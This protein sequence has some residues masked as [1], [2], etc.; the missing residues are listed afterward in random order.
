MYG[1]YSVESVSLTLI[2]TLLAAL[3]VL[4]LG[5]AGTIQGTGFA[6]GAEPAQA[7]AELAA[8]GAG[9]HADHVA[10]PGPDITDLAAP[11]DAGGCA[12]LG[13]CVGCAMHCSLMAVVGDAAAETLQPTAGRFA[14][15][16]DIGGAGVAST[17]ERPPAAV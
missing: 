10:P 11:D 16:A 7:H 1:T 14:K 8:D 13:H 12:D 6:A 4:G 15:V 5:F 3:V 17:L 2:R 9:R